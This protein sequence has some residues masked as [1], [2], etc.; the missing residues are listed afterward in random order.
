MTDKTLVRLAKYFWVMP[1]SEAVQERIREGFER[2]SSAGT[3]REYF[4]ERYHIGLQ[5]HNKLEE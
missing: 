2:L 1:S 5:K 4:G 3:F